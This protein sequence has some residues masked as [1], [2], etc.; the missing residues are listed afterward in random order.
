MRS[1]GRVCGSAK[2]FVS[3]PKDSAFSLLWGNLQGPRQLEIK[4]RLGRNRNIPIPGQ[5]R[6]CHS[7]SAS[8]ARA[9]GS[10]FAAARQRADD[11]PRAR[12]DR[13][14]FGSPL[15]AAFTSFTE[16]AGVICVPVAVALDRGQSDALLGIAF[17]PARRFRVGYFAGNLRS[18]RN[19]L[20][21]TFNYRF[22][23]RSFH[24][25]SRRSVL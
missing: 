18:A 19:Y 3:V 6:S 9:D 16:G 8:G 21:V 7:C 15:S 5:R 4:L 11:R 13:G 23:Q 14:T 10:A 12:A 24:V 2:R 20:L 22:R 17:E 25:Q 1:V